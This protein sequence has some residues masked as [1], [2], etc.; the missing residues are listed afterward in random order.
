MPSDVLSLEGEEEGEMEKREYKN[1]PILLHC[2]QAC[3]AIKAKHGY[4]H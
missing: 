2:G 4:Q 3:F 1:T